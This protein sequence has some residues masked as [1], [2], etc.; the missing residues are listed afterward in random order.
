MDDPGRH[1]LRRDRMPWV[2]K[3][4][5]LR[6][7]SVAASFVLAV[8]CGGAEPMASRL[9]TCADLIRIEPI[10]GQIVVPVGGSQRIRLQIREPSRREKQRYQHCSGLSGVQ[11]N[12]TIDD[13]SVARI[14]EYSAAVWTIE[15]L[16]VGQ[17]WIRLRYKVPRI[18]I[19]TRLKVVES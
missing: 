6:M 4:R 7:L 11:P 8:G 2:R 18:G 5:G 1:R 15:A 12:W 9:Y 16:A 19:Y 3:L 14:E 10:G 13:P 17:T